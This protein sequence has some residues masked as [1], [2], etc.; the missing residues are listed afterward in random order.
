[1]DDVTR[2]IVWRMSRVWEITQRRCAETCVAVKT[3]RGVNGRRARSAATGRGPPPGA[4]RHRSSLP[5]PNAVSIAILNMHT[6]YLFMRCYPLSH[7][8]YF[9][10]LFILFYLILSYIIIRTARWYDCT[11]VLRA[12]CEE[13]II[14]CRHKVFIL[15]TYLCHIYY[16]YLPYFLH[17]FLIIPDMYHFRN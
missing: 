8:K 15:D 2:I 17:S 9:T 7:A 14:N 6:Y 10:Y 3:W 16:L 13:G 12:L 5:V 1:M 4:V 11:R